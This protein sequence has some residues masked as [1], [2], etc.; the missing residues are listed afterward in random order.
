VPQDT[1]SAD[2]GKPTSTGGSGQGSGSMGTP[3][4][5]GGAGSGDDKS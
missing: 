2:V 4:P 1:T 5:V 3:N